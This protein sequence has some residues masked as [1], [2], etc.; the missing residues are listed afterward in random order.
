[1]ELC[2]QNKRDPLYFCTTL[3]PENVIYKYKYVYSQL[4]VSFPKFSC[5]SGPPLTRP[6][7]VFWYRQVWLRANKCVN[8]PVTIPIDILFGCPDAKPYKGPISGTD[9]LNLARISHK[10]SIIVSHLDQELFQLCLHIRVDLCVIN[11]MRAPC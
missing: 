1:M 7:V 4:N 3:C 9:F 6:C 10:N 5:I 8:F 11:P 2:R